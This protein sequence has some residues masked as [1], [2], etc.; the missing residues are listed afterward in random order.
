MKGSIVDVR[1]GITQTPKELEVELA[2]DTDRD[3][4]LALIERKSEGA[5][6]SVPVAEAPPAGEVV[7]IVS[8]LK[9]SLDEAKRAHG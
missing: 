9:R 2:D 4:L 3:A 7:D 8:L 1:I 5:K 6:V